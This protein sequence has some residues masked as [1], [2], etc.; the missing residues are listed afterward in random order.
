MSETTRIMSQA[1]MAK[2]PESASPARS[3]RTHDRPGSPASRMF[4]LQQTAGNSA[5]Q[6]IL[7]SGAIQ[8]S[9]RIG[10]PNDL[11]EL[12]ADRVAD[13]VMRMPEPGVQRQ[14]SSRNRCPLKDKEEKKS[15]I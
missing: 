2:R 1:D 12:E 4:A 8:A 15:R 5:V 9:I 13:Q 10:Q 7:K 3:S 14:C 11:Y 6:K